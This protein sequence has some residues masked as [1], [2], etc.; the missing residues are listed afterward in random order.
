MERTDAAD[1]GLCTLHAWL[2]SNPVKAS[3]RQS[4][5]T[6]RTPG[7]Q[8]RHARQVHNV[9]L[10]TR[11][12][13]TV[14][15][16]LKSSVRPTSE[17]GPEANETAAEK[18]ERDLFTCCLYIKGLDE[19]AFQAEKQSFHSEAKRA[20]KQRGLGCLRFDVITVNSRL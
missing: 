9:L 13:G 1:R 14:L 5:S 7:A 17:K 12:T 3:R 16:G 4:I 18:K 20:R 10:A 2:M 19:T 11:T 6:G 15:K 8:L